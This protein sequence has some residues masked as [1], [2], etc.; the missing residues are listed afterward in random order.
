[1]FSSIAVSLAYERVSSFFFVSGVLY[2]FGV[3]VVSVP[4][5]LICFFTFI[6]FLPTRQ[7][8]KNKLFS[9]Q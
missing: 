1:M 4:F 7:K 9:D 6:F 5:D 2:V 3:H 8:Q